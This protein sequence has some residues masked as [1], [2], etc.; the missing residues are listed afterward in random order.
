MTGYAFGDTDLAARRLARLAET[1]E[2]SSAAFM[3]RS[4]DFRPRLAVDLGCGPGYSTH[5]L[6]DALS[7]E[8]TVGLDNSESFLT[9][10]RATVSKGVSFHLHDITTTPFPTG[11]CDVMFGRFEL[12][13]L[14][15]PE[16]VVRLWGEQLRVRG[17]LLIEEVEYID[18]AEPILKSYLDMQQAMLKQQGN[19]LYIG[20]RLDAILDSATMKRRA[21]EVQALGVPANQAAAMFLMNFG[22]WRHNGFVQRT[23]GAA[24]LDD[25]ESHLQ[26]VA[27]GRIENAPVEWGLRQIVMERVA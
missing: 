4:V 22:V 17:R 12:T 7:P 9:H 20:P 14:R 5:L 2:E 24:A 27:E 26:A 3:R 19:A 8:R 23:Y 13:H 10:A 11:F 21:S 15:D 6:A 25:L 16:A 1:F 18:T